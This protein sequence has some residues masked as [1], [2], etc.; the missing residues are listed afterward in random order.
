MTRNKQENYDHTVYSPPN[1]DENDDNSTDVGERL[2]VDE[3]FNNVE[4]ET[5]DSTVVDAV[6]GIVT[7]AYVTVAA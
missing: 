1:N 6:A 5:D 2:D 7:L 4:D 3:L